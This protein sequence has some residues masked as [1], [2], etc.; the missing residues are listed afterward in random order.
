MLHFSCIL[1][2]P[3]GSLITLMWFWEPKNGHNSFL[4]DHFSTSLHSLRI[5][6]TVCVTVPFR[7]IYVNELFS[8]WLVCIV[9]DSKSSTR[10]TPYN[11]WSGWVG[12]E[13]CRLNREINVNELVFVTSQKQWIQNRLFLHACVYIYGLHGPESVWYILNMLTNIRSSLKY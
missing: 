11:L 2:S 13:L 12:L 4:H 7:V 1:F 9:P 10:N 6:Q 3:W 5:K 8:D